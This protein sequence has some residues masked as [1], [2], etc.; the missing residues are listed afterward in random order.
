MVSWVLKNLK[1]NFLQNIETKLFRDVAGIDEA[2]AELE[3]VVEF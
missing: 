2:K 1:L 3:E